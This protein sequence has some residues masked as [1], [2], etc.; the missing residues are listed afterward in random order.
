VPDAEES[1]G[2]GTT[3]AVWLPVAGETAAKLPEQTAAQP[4][5]EA[6]RLSVLVVDDDDLVLMNTA[7]MLEDLGQ[8]VLEATSGARRSTSCRANEISIWSSQ[9]RQAA[10]DR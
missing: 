9:I 5:S 4:E 7:A 2:Q 10:D 6:R 3:A 1:E 8:H